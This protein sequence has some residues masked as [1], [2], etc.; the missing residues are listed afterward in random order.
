MTTTYSYPVHTYSRY[1]NTAWNVFVL[2]TQLYTYT[3][4]ERDPNQFV[5]KNIL[6]VIRTK[7][8]QAIVVESVR[9]QMCQD[10]AVRVCLGAVYLGR[11]ADSR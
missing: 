11:R 10:Y 3:Y 2:Y 6:V 7:S 5:Y 8:K 9:K 4:I 1:G